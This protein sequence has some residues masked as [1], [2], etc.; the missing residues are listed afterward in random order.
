MYQGNQLRHQ[1]YLLV[2]QW[3][4]LFVSSGEN[5]SKFT[6]ATF[7]RDIGTSHKNGQIKKGSK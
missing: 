5:A 6:N 1:S 4:H 3:Q 2:A 7:W